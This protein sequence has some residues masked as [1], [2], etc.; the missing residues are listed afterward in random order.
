MVLEPYDVDKETLG[1]I[2]KTVY[3]H[4]KNDTV[5]TKKVEEEL[6]RERR[7]EQLKQKR[8]GPKSEFEF[9]PNHFDIENQLRKNNPPLSEYD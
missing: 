4:L 8:T 1:V 7:Y 5:L 3:R 2:S 6:L 9:V